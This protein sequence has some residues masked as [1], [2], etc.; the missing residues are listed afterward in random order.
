VIAV[1]A[2]PSAAADAR[3]NVGAAGLDNVQIINDDVEHFLTTID[4]S[5]P[6][7]VADP[8]LK[9]LGA[10]V[11]RHLVSLRPRRL[12]YVA[13]D[14]ATLARDAR[15]ITDTDYRLVEVQPLDLLPQT[16]H[17]E[18]VALFERNALA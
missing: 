18:C 8:P 16:Y 12:V 10:D 14:P 5:V 4:E 15:I 2:N 3:F 17:V 13:C 11:V 9:G 7:V 6:S 1:E